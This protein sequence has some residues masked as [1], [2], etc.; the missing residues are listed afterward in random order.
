MYMVK[1]EIRV[2]DFDEQI[3][4]DITS[5][6]N[7]G[8]IIVPKEHIGKEAM[9][10]VKKKN[11]EDTIWID[12]IEYIIDEKMAKRQ[13]KNLGG[14][15]KAIEWWEKFKLIVPEESKRANAMIE[16]IKKVQ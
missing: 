2:S 6:G 12:G 8:H 10:L 14:K 1:K 3:E 7:S 15:T 9:V 4:R 11:I 5:F 16:E 13:I